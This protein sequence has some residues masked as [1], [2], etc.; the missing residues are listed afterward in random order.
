VTL[1]APFASSARA[2]RIDGNERAP[3]KPEFR[4]VLDKATTKLVARN[5]RVMMMAEPMPP[6]L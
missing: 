4:D 2:V 3:C 1:K 6:S 5:E